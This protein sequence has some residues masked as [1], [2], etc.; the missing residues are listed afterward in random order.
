LR[1]N[2]EYRSLNWENRARSVAFPA[3]ATGAYGFRPAL[4]ARIAVET[5]RSAPTTVEQVLL[6]AFDQSAREM[7]EAA[8]NR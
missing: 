5:I 6:V 1:V 2:T 7:L 4:A 3:I 8:L